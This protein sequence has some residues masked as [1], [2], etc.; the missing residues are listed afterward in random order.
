MHAM[1]MQWGRFLLHHNELH[2]KISL[3]WFYAKKCKN[4]KPNGLLSCNDE[5]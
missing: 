3:R 2:V 4:G 1:G 5:G